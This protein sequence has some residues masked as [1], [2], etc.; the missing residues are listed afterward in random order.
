MVGRS[1]SYS[2]RVGSSSIIS[3]LSNV[4]LSIISVIVD[5]LGPAVRESHR[6]GAIHNTGTI[7]GLSGIESGAGVIIGHS[8]VVSVGRDLI[9]VG[10]R[11][12]VDSVDNRS[13]VDH[14]GSMDNRSVNNGCSVVNHGSM[15]NHRSMDSMD[16]VVSHGMTSKEDVLRAGEKLGSCHGRGNLRQ[17]EE[18]LHVVGVA[19]C[20]LLPPC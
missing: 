1:Y 8:V 9:R 2:L 7:A 6:V 19:D 11:G 4:T 13:S 3:D 10:Y 17:D 12:S 20:S 15:M 18:G 14:G 16:G 5:M